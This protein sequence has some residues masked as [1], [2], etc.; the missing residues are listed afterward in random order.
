MFPSYMKRYSDYFDYYGSH[1]FKIFTILAQ[2][3]TI[4]HSGYYMIQ[5]CEIVW[6]LS[7]NSV[8]VGPEKTPS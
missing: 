6:N 4:S 3:H 1:F 5:G 8:I 2:K 7:V